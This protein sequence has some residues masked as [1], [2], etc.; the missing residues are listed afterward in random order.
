MGKEIK[1]EKKRKKDNKFLEVLN[2]G[3]Y[4]VLH[5]PPRWGGGEIKGLET[6]KKCK[7]E[8]RKFGETKTFGST[9]F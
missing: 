6:G 8:K 7:G 9:K 5:S 2:P 1:G 3:L 4:I